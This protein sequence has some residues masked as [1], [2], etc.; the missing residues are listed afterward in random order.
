MLVSL[1]HPQA[2]TRLALVAPLVSAPLSK[3]MQLCTTHIPQAPSRTP[4]S[5]MCAPTIMYGSLSHPPSLAARSSVSHVHA[6]PHG[7]P[8]LACMSHPCQ[9]RTT[10]YIPHVCYTPSHVYA[11]PARNY[12][13]YMYIMYIPRTYDTCGQRAPAGTAGSSIG[14]AL[15]R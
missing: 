9:L 15:Q 2:P 10:S 5:S 14:G 8:P 1:L 3:A 6:L 12:V 4:I 7:L 13:R 11:H